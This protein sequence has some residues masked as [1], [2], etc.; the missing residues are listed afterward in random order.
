M[1]LEELK[2]MTENNFDDFA[3]IVLMISLVLLFVILD[4]SPPTDKDN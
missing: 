2:N 3:F 4:S 1:A